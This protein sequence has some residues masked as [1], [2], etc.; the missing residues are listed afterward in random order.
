MSSFLYSPLNDFTSV[1][2]WHF[3]YYK[4][5]LKSWISEKFGIL[6]ITL[7]YLPI[8]SSLEVSLEFFGNMR[9]NENH[10]EHYREGSLYEVWNV[11]IGGQRLKT[12]LPVMFSLGSIHKRVNSFICL[13]WMFLRFGEMICH[14]PN[15]YWYVVINNTIHFKLRQPLKQIQI[16]YQITFFFV[17]FCFFAFMSPGQPSWLG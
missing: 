5:G 4:K 6:S 16:I 10:F 13:L 2:S 1:I 17:L 8:Q 15:Q 14:T 11:W 12:H 3:C 7:K 9:K